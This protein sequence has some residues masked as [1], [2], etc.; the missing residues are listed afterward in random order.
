M[1]QERPPQPAPNDRSNEGDEY[2]IQFPPS[3]LPVGGNYTSITNW[4]LNL[5]QIT[6]FTASLAPENKLRTPSPAPASEEV[7]TEYLSVIDDVP[8]GYMNLPGPGATTANEEQLPEYMNFQP[9]PSSPAPAL[10]PRNC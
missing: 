8:M 10:P 7:S 6:T 5:T 1:L 9:A 4:N 2:Y 3:G